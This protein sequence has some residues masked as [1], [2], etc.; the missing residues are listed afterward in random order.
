MEWIELEAPEELESSNSD[1]SFLFPVFCMNDIMGGMRMDVRLT[2][3]DD[4]TVRVWFNGYI[5]EYVKV[6]KSIKGSRWQPADKTWS[7]PYT[8]HH[9]ERLIDGFGLE[10]LQADQAL[11]DECYLLQTVGDRK[12]QPET[13]RRKTTVWDVITIPCSLSSAVVRI[14]MST[15]LLARSNFTTNV[16]C[17][18]KKKAAYIRPKKES[19]LPQVLSLSEIKR[20]IRTVTN[21]KHKA[22]LILTY[23]S[24]L[25]VSEVVKLRYND[26]DP[27]RK[28]LLVRQGKGRKDRVTLLSELSF[29]NAAAVSRRTWT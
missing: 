15:K 9:I 16:F 22:L 25:R 12:P 2:K 19:K 17:L 1:S 26:L 8:L 14:R 3:K 27:E 24:G 4:Y 5:P 28:T 11:R 7:V 23:S 29:Y 6:M 18:S 10:R 13:V 20:M 21:L